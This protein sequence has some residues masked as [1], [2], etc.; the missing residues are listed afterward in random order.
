MA[1]PTKLST[2]QTVEQL[3]PWCLGMGGA[4]DRVTTG[5][6]YPAPPHVQ[7]QGMGQIL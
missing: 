3:S 4:Q 1:K 7:S 6:S 2:V 5:E